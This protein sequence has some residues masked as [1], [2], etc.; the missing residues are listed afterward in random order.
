M[1]SGTIIVTLVFFAVILIPLG[2]LSYN[3]KRKKDKFLKQF[4]QSAESEGF[5]LTK[6]EVCCNMAIGVDEAKKHMIFSKQNDDEIASENYDLTQFKSCELLKYNRNTGDKSSGLNIIYKIE[7]ALISPQ[8]NNPSVKIE[9]FN[10]EME[11]STLTNELKF[12]EKWETILNDILKSS[13]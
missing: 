13:E 9:L 8:K 3:K 1:N 2:L 4:M 11:N 10:A 12:G 7:L 5:S 6:S